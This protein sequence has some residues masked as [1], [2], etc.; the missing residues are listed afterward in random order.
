[1]SDEGLYLY[2]QPAIDEIKAGNAMQE[3]NFTMD[4]TGL[5]IVVDVVNIGQ[6]ANEDYAILRKNGLGGSDSSSILGVNPYTSREELIK[7]KARRHLTEE[8]KLIGEK[9]A[10]KKGRDLEPLI[11]Q[12]FENYFQQETFKP[13]DMYRWVDQPY[14]KVNFDGVTGIPGQY[15]PAEIKVVTAYGQKH[16]AQDKAMFSENMGFRP[17][18]DNVSQHNWSIETKAG[19]YGIPP[20]YYT[21]LQ[22][23]IAALNAPF[24]HLSVL[25]DKDWKFYSFFI[26]RDDA[27]IT[28]LKT[29]GYKVWE[30]VQALRA[31]KQEWLTNPIDISEMKPLEPLQLGTSSPSF[32]IEF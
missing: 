23:Q 21:Q 12:K 4:L 24:G 15:I 19:F 20:Y 18:P 6:Y 29:E 7:E 17:L 5:P 28:A 9:T 32:K 3:G 11:I 10:V 25:F 31:T 2:N 22:A 13:A 30:K 1:M 8:E 27:V 16:Y 14:M 26:W